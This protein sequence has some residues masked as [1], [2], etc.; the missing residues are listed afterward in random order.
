[1]CLLLYLGAN[2]ALPTIS[3]NQDKPAF[4]IGLDDNPPF[5]AIEYLQTKYIYYVGSHEGCGCGFGY[6]S[7]QEFE[8]TLYDEMSDDFKASA[9]QDREDRI[10]CMNSLREYLTIVTI[11]GPVKLLITW[12]DIVESIEKYEIVTPD[13]FG[14]DVCCIYQ[15]YLFEIQQVNTP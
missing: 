14:G 9:K 5:A 1:M 6:E 3:G 7:T 13:Y 10:A 12:G 11:D 4:Y 8:E 15:N 2:R